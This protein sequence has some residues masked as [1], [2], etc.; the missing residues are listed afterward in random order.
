M[1]RLSRIIGTASLFIDESARVGEDCDEEKVGFIDD[2]CVDSEYRGKD[3]VVVLMDGIK[4]LAWATGCQ[5]VLI[6]ADSTKNG[7]KFE[8]N[9]SYYTAGGN[10]EED[11]GEIDLSEA[12]QKKGRDAF[13]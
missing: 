5:K 6:K 10:D 9:Q 4:S 2:I 7:I 12:N 1:G 3:E 11:S 8:G 13:L